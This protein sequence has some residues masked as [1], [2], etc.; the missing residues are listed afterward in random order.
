MSKKFHDLRL[1]MDAWAAH[2]QLFDEAGIILP[3]EARAYVTEELRRNY[4][5]MDA[6]PSLST[7][8]NSGIPA[9]LTTLVDPEVYEILF[10]PTKAAEILGEK[11]KGNWVDQTAMFPTVEQTGEVSSYGDFNENGR[12]GANVNFPQRQS[13]L[14]QTVSEYGELEVERAGLARVNWV[15]E[16]D[17]SG[18]NAL[19]RFLN[20]TYFRGVVGLQNYGV[21]NDP[22]LSAA[23]TPST[24]AAGGTKWVTNGAITAT[25]N[26]IYADIQAMFLQ[27]IKQTNGLVD[28]D[29]KM[30]LALSPQSDFAM[31][32]TNSFGVNVGELIKKNL[33]NLRVVSAV[34]YGAS[35]STNPVGNAA[36]E[37]VQLI[38]DEIEGQDSGFVAFNEKLRSHPIVRAMSSWK[39]KMTSGTWGAVIRMPMGIAQMVGV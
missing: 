24:K 34:Q 22:N 15:S 21:L 30:T 38:A 20:Q 35:G 10:A 39:K 12:S 25:A 36:G 27:L 11:R 37:L 29:T 14:F 1:A 19:A 28:K 31:T 5:A 2:R 4:L 8:A 9:F 32:A 26:E 7:E 6:Q 23:I 18:T 16:V 17:K 3:A 33:K 13:Y